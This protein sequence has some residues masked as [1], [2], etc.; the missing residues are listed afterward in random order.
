[1]DESGGTEGKRSG[2]RKWDEEQMNKKRE[3]FVK[4]SSECIETGVRM[5]MRM[6][7]KMNEGCK[8]LRKHKNYQWETP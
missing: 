4:I 5:R 8:Q 7:E 2:G 6:V 1:M 3:A